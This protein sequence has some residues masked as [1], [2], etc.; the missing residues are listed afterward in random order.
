MY[1]YV[2]I[3]M[4]IYI[5]IERERLLIINILSILIIMACVIRNCKTV[6]ATW[7]FCTCNKTILYKTVHATKPYCKIITI[8]LCP[9]EYADISF[10]FVG[11]W[12]SSEPSGSWT[13]CPVFAPEAKALPKKLWSLWRLTR[14]VDGGWNWTRDLRTPAQLQ[15]TIL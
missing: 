2:Y 1:I 9:A 8:R 5:Y 15:T 3:H 12:W 7:G 14:I 13:S 4:C 11:C 10:Y 6:H